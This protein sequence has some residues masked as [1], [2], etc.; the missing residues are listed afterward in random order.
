MN[1]YYTITILFFMHVSAKAQDVHFS[2]FFAAPL[3]YNPANTGNF[4]G[5][6]RVGLNYKDQWG[7]FTVPYTSYDL[8]SDVVIQPKQSVNRFGIGL[9]ALNDIAGD[10]VL[11]SSRLQASTSYHINYK[12]EATWRFAFGMSGAYVQ[13]TLDIYKL[14]FDSQW[15]A[16]E[17]NVSLSNNESSASNK[18]NYYDFSAGALLT[19]IPYEGERYYFGLAAH[20]INKPQESFYEDDNTIHMK[21]VAQAG[22]LFQISTNAT[23]QPQVFYTQQSSASEI[24]AG[25][26]M[27]MRMYYFDK[28]KYHALIL[29]A[30]YRYKDAAWLVAGMNFDGFTFS[31]NYDFNL[32]QLTPA[33]KAKGGIEFALVYTLTRKD[34][35]D[36]FDC[37]AFE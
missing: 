30:W 33:S 23:L 28:E 5:S 35:H 19:H 22:A 26:N 16:D 25:T 21:Y 13:K 4:S 12:P 31:V 3:Y 10:G 34:K 14:T 37:P 20:H 29:G 7:S 32:S 36:P 8:Y 2:Q 27:S 1:K 17:F 24:I 11:T 6:W 15:D 18:L 9:L